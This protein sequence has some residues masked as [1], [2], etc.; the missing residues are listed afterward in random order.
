MVRKREAEEA[1]LRMSRERL[2][3][4]KIEA[5][6]RR[7]ELEIQILERQEAEIRRKAESEQ[8]DAQLYFDVNNGV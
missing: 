1:E 6:I 7:Q 3:Q 4:R 8:I 5:E 2:E